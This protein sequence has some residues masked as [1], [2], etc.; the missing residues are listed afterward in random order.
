[1]VHPGDEFGFVL[2][3]RIECAVGDDVF[4]LQPGE[5]AYFDAQCPHRSRNASEGEAAYL[6]VVTP[7]SF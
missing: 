2:S 3:G 7:P 5:S 6:L 1:M 4:P